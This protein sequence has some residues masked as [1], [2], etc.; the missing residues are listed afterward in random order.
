MHEKGYAPA[1]ALFIMQISKVLLL[2]QN[3]SDKNVT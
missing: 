1:A 2:M 3:L